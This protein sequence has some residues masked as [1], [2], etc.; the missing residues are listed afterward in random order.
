MSARLSTSVDL[1]DFRILAVG[2]RRVIASGTARA[3]RIALNESA[4]YARDHHRHTKR[5]GRLTSKAELFGEMRQADENGAWGYLTN[6]T[7]YARIIEFGSRAHDIWP[8][9][10]FRMIGPVRDGQN[11]RAEGRGPHEHIVGRGIA[12]R[13][14]VG[15]KVVFARMVKHP[16]TPALPFMHPAAEHARMVIERETETVTFQ[17]VAEL[18]A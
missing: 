9:A 4:D 2:T 14:K 18:W 3:V 15:G 12:L 17:R 7:P 16:G 5:T 6:T 8:K 10:A 11:R 1:T 13:F